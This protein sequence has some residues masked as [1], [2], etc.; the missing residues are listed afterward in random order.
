M[1]AVNK[2]VAPIL[3]TVV[4]TVLVP[5]T[6]AGI[7][8]WLL[9]ETSAVEVGGGQCWAAFTVVALGIAIYLHTAFWGLAVIGGGTP[10]PI[11]PTKTL[12]VQGLHRFVRNPMYIGVLLIIAG[13]AWLFWSRSL[14]LYAALLW[15]AF[16][17]F[18]VT[19]EEPILRKQFGEGYDRYRASVPRWIPRIRL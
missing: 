2:R 1:A 4:F 9:R 7:V 3:K 6:V 10:A 13:Q 8:P 16:H 5:G 18:V 17:L 19:Y 12:V 11:A 15:L 14:C